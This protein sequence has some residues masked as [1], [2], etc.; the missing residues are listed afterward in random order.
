[1]VRIA[2]ALPKTCPRPVVHGPPSP[3]RAA[4]DIL[5]LAEPRPDL[6]AC[7]AAIPPAP[8]KDAALV[9]ERQVIIRGLEARCGDELAKL[10]RT[11][12]TREDGCSPFQI[13]KRAY[14]TLVPVMGATK[15]L[16]VRAR[17][18]AD[19]GDAE[20]A[21]WILVEIAALAQDL[22]RGRSSILVRAVGSSIAVTAG[23]HAMEIANTS[24]LSP[25]AIDALAS[26][27]DILLASEPPMSDV[28]QSELDSF[29]L[30][31]Y[32]PRMKPEDW[33]PAGGWLTGI[34]EEMKPAGEPFL[35]IREEV[36]FMM[37]ANEAQVASFSV[38]CPRTANARSC[39]DG[40][41]TVAARA[42][43]QDVSAL[44]LRLAD[45]ALSKAKN[46]QRGVR[47]ALLDALLGIAAAS[48]LTYIPKG[49]GVIARFGALRVHLEILR[50]AAANKRCPTVAELDAAPFAALRAPAALGDQLRIE[51]VAAGFEIKTPTWFKS[52]REPYQVR[53]PATAP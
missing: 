28:I 20:A 39:H 27:L 12:T 32:L 36:G 5:A 19:A 13:G 9:E 15:L 24:P 35:D 10:L 51:A 40:L 49:M 4:P 52:K 6:A 3:G 11:A 18:I 8:A 46:A 17:R 22:Y 16:G 2:A 1:M 48:Y 31:E 23:D 34:K 44:F 30:H 38:A 26:G 50:F 47:Q 14:P 41:A 25:R 53:C 29:A 42:T 45:L 33:V 7:M 21:L 43:D 37:L